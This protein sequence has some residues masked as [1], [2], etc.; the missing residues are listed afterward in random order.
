MSELDGLRL[1][2]PGR[3]LLIRAS[4][5]EPIVRIMSEAESGEEANRLCREVE[6]VLANYSA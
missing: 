4:N 3:W 6:G 2:W 5:T 1:D